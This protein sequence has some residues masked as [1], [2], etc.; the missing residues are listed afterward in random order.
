MTRTGKTW[1]AA[2]SVL[3]VGIAVLERTAAGRRLSR[4]MARHVTQVARY[5]AGRLDGLRYR[6][7]GGA[8]DPTATDAVLA[9]RVRSM[10]GPTEQRLDVPHV[11]VSAR[12][13]DVLLHGD[14]GSAREAAEIVDR[15]Q[16]VPGV[17][18]VES[19]LHVGYGSGDTRPSDGRAHRPQSVAMR[20]LLAAAHGGGAPA[21]TERATVRSVL[22]TFAGALPPGERRH[23]LG[24]LPADV[25]TLVTGDPVVVHAPIRRLD[26]F[27]VAALPTLAPDDRR[28]VVESVLGALRELVPEEDQDVSAVLAE[29]L[30]HLWKTA[31]PL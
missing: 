25:R 6:L 3:A 27:A 2:G 1:V 23:V 15:A 30:R 20:R 14:V 16:A 19:H 8:P 17:G 11:L 9:D 18:R 5:E 10:L 21:G 7:R 4:R 28:S 22:C 29:E 24:H 31:I 26:D 12:G 13:H